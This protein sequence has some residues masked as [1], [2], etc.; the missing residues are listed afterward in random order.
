MGTWICHLR[1][2][3]A[4]LPD[5]PQL[6]PI[7][8]SFGN[9]APDSGIPNADWSSFDPPK[10]VTHFLRS[11]EGEGR[12][13]DLTF[14]YTYVVPAQHDSD[15]AC[16]SFLLGYFSHLLCDNLWSHRIGRAC[17]QAYAHHFHQDTQATWTKLKRDWYDL[18]HRYVRDHPASLFWR[19]YVP[20]PNPPMYVPLVPTA[21]LHQQLDYIRTFYSQ[22]AA[23]RHL[24]RPYPYLN[25]QT[26]T[27]FVTETVGDIRFILGHTHQLP[28]LEDATTALSLL[29]PARLAPYAMPLGD[30]Q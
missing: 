14:Y 8:F 21:A 28:S 3:E 18:D 24:D 15:V 16:V 29:D 12:I 25:E 23:S 22:S 11:G 27:R 1:I 19:V 6:D 4:L 17:K 7:A 5:F 26:M 2:A 10:E 9:L 20:A 30:V 13:R